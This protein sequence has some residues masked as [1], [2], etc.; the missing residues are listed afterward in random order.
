MPQEVKNQLLKCLITKDKNIK[1]ITANAVAA[2][3]IHEFQNKQWLDLIP[4]L[5]NNLTH[6]DVEVK[7][8]AIMT[9]GFLCETLKDKRLENFLEAKQIEEVLK[10]ILLGLKKDEQD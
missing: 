10:G 3:A 5:A 7:K 9:L 6:T 1:R 4:N 8:A 2:L